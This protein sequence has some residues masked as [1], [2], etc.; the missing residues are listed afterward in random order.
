MQLLGP[1]RALE[2]LSSGRLVGASEA[3]QLGL[4]NASIYHSTTQLINHQTTKDNQLKLIKTKQTNNDLNDENH[5]HNYNHQNGNNNKNS[6][7]HDHMDQTTNTTKTITITTTT[8][9]NNNNNTPTMTPPTSQLISNNN[10]NHLDNGSLVVANR[11]NGNGNQ[12]NTTQNNENV[13]GQQQQQ[14][15][16]NN[17]NNHHNERTTSTKIEPVFTRSCDVNG[18]QKGL[19]GHELELSAERREALQFLCQHTIGNLETIKALKSMINAA[20]FEPL[21][22]ALAKEAHLFA[23]TWG[24]EAHLAALAGNLKHNR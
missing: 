8:T 16:I 11:L 18:N 13:N 15:N 19:S 3:L 17:N 2:L 4:S 5:H 9:T 23:S 20:R 14:L 6:N 10:T 22:E 7:N 12:W 21:Q 24:K 1:S